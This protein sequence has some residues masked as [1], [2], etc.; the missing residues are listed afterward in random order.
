MQYKYCE[1]NNFED[2]SC[3]RVIIHRTG[4]PNFPVR[5]AQEIYCRCVSYL[6][7]EKNICIYDPCCGGGYLLTVLGFLNVG[8]IT[9]IIASDISEEALELVKQNLSLLS[10]NGLEKRII[11]LQELYTK[12][13]KQS[14]LEALES[15]KRLLY[16]I[17]GSSIYQN[18]CVFQADVL[19][20]LPSNDNYLKADVVIMDVP[21]GNLVSWCGCETNNTN[22]LLDNLTTVL[23]QDAIVAI[24]SNKL[25]KFNST[26]FVR[27]EKQI[28]GK[29]KFEIFQIRKN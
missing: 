27:V 19:S 21:Y 1:N 7:R 8:S 11:M 14:H 4:F 22:V 12:Y 9:S 23:K 18:S 15:S 16:K 24:C 10:E 17:K 13:Q 3:G 5:L 20:G 25:Q 6:K 2:L 28:I 29:R 26:K